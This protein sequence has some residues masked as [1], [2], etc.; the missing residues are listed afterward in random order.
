[1]QR[2]RLLLVVLLI[3]LVFAIGAGLG[4]FVRHLA[5][6][7]SGTWALNT[8]TVLRQVQ[9]LSQLVTVKYVME[10]VIVL[11]DVK[12]YGENRVLMV[13]LGI[14]KAGVD[15]GKLKT[16]DIRVSGKKITF[17]LPPVQIT[18]TYLDDKRTENIERTTGALRLFDKDLEQTARKNA[19]AD[20]QI[21]AR[22]A[23]IMKDAQDRAEIQAKALFQQMGFEEVEIV[24]R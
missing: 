16:E 11:E 7:Q 3:F 6:G 23:G 4:F 10:K 19:V 22:G 5:A 24:P 1:M 21:A 13:A 8:A 20:I 15:V 18:D 9:S 2:I 12:W 17:R 14:V